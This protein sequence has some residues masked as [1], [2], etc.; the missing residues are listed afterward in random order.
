MIDNLFIL[1]NKLITDRKNNREKHI[2]IKDSKSDDKHTYV[3]NVLHYKMCSAHKKLTTI[4]NF[5]KQTKSLDGY[6]SICVTC[7]SDISYA[8]RHNLPVKLRLLEL[9]PDIKF[10]KHHKIISD[11]SNLK[12]LASKEGIKAVLSANI[13]NLTREERIDIIKHLIDKLIT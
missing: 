12:P 2:I 3:N 8:K 10:V 1:E 9:N 4:E 5:N 11:T 13:S 7:K 6:Q